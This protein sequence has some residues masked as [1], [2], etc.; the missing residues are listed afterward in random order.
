MQNIQKRSR[1][2]LLSILVILI[3]TGCT[4]STPTPDP[5]TFTPVCNVPSLIKAINDANLTTAIPAEIELPNNCL[6][7]LKEVDNTVLWQGLS[8]HSGL[9]AIISEIT[10]RG[11]NSVI[12]ILPDTGEAH[13]GH[14][15]LDYL[16]TTS[17]SSTTWPIR[18]AWMMLP[19]GARST[20]I[21]VRS[22]LWQTPSSSRILQARL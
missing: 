4:P 1:W 9:P 21:S 2:I 6:Y 20:V 10:I 7:T 17:S 14:F 19:K 13:F 11:N 15:F 3:L 12:E 5:T 22:G 16:P 8:I 18:Q